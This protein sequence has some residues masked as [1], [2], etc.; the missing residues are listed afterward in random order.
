MLMPQSY[1]PHERRSVI[2][3]LGALVMVTLRNFL[4]RAYGPFNQP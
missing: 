2:R 1:A 4:F 3:E